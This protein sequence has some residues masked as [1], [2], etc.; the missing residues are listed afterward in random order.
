MQ[1]FSSIVR[2]TVWI[3]LFLVLLVQCYSKIILLLLILC[4]FCEIPSRAWLRTS[5]GYDNVVTNISL[6]GFCM[7]LL[8]I[9][10]RSIAV[11]LK[12]TSFH[13][14]SYCTLKTAEDL[15]GW[16]EY[17]LPLV[18]RSSSYGV[19]WSNCDKYFSRLTRL[20]ISRF[21]SDA[22]CHV[23]FLTFFHHPKDRNRI[24]CIG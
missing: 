16:F 19:Q 21:C 15:A 13:Y 9:L 1:F 4:V 22:H 14:L 20:L 10:V 6:V 3:I 18:P 17:F 12:I 23:V 11:L 5:M 24:I 7:V 2:L 8:F